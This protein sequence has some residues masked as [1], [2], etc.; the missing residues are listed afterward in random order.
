VVVD[1]ASLPG[2]LV[3]SILFGHVKGAFT[4]ADANREGLVKQAH[5]GT[6][7]LDEVGELPYAMQRKFLRV[8]EQHSFRP[9]GAKYEET[10]DFR[11]VAATNRDL[12]QLVEAKRFRQDLLFRIRSFNIELPPLRVRVSDIA[13]IVRMHMDRMGQRLGLPEQNFSPEFMDALRAYPWPGNVRELVN[14]LERSMAASRNAPT[15]YLM[16]L[17][18]NVRAHYAR[19]LVKDDG[20]G[21]GSPGVNK[22]RDRERPSQTWGDFREQAMAEA[23]KKYFRQVLALTSGDVKETCRIAGVSRARLYQILQKTGLSRT[24]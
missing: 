15:L 22:A 14:C 23:E 12:D 3:E 5:G 2:N 10:S 9:V 24:G 21:D 13:E 18:E 6:L 16:H 19:T 8:L 1:C 11:V 17:P 4:G 7:F 20:N